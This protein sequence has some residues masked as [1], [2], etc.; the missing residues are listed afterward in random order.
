MRLTQHFQIFVLTMSFYVTHL[1]YNT[2]LF[3]SCNV[4]KKPISTFTNCRW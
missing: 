2:D 4:F 3:Q 1:N